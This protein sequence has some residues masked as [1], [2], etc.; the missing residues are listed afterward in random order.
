LFPGIGSV[1][2]NGFAATLPLFW[3]VGVGVVGVIVMLT[4]AVPP[5]ASVP[6]E[7]CTIDPVGAEHVPGLLLIEPKVAPLLGRL[8]TNVTPAVGS[9]PLFV[10]VYV[11]VTGLPTPTAFPLLS[12]ELAVLLMERSLTG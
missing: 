3:N 10:T 7:H 6:T 11:N 4:V 9:G 8:S 2:N 1:E 12:T 5:L